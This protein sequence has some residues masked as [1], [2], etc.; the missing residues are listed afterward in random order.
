VNRR[1]DA[2]RRRGAG[3]SAI[4]HRDALDAKFRALG[5]E[6]AKERE[7][8]TKE[9]LAK[10]TASLEQFAA[11]HRSD[12]RADPEFRAAFHAMCANVGVDPLASRK[13]AWGQ[14]LGFGEFYVELAVCVADCCLASR[15]HDGGLCTLDALVE[16]VNKRRGS[17]AGDVSTDDV[18]RAIEALGALGG[19]WSV[20]ASASASASLGRNKSN[21]MVRSVPLEMS[22]DVNACIARARETSHGCLS[23]SALAETSGWTLERARDA[24]ESAV[25]LGISLVDDQHES[26]ARAYWFPAFRL[27]LSGD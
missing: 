6:R 5:V 25:K 24:L 16:R 12:I 26:G 14:L 17:V 20:D 2:M 7:E 23:A 10:F 11:A 13:S 8:Q 3:V 21:K 22:D 1:L 4:A 19:G 27:E 9:Q 15:A 18:E